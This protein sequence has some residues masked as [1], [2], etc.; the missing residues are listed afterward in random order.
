MPR[1]QRP[2]RWNDGL[3]GSALRVLRLLDS[4]Q[5]AHEQGLTGCRYADRGKFG[6]PS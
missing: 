5:R 6:K 1:I 3:I 4:G 2:S